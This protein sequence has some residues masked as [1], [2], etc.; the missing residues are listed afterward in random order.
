LNGTH[1]LLTYADDINLL[2]DNIDI[3]KKKTETLL[4]DSKE[5]GLDI[6]REN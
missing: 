5:V 2:R 3:I 1:Q 4:Y 6:K